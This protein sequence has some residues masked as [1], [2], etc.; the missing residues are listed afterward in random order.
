MKEP[1]GKYRK[2]EIATYIIMAVGLILFLLTPLL[3]RWFG[4]DSDVLGL[5]IFLIGLA[6][7]IVGI[8]VRSIMRKVGSHGRIK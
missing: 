4:F 6:M 8:I 5:L 7:F 2:Y 1:V 3:I